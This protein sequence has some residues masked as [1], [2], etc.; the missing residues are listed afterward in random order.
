MEWLVRK[1]ASV[2]TL[3]YQL[4]GMSKIALRVRPSVPG[5]EVGLK[6]LA[7]LATSVVVNGVVVEK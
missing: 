7:A 5:P 1:D 3:E 2:A 6:S 4:V